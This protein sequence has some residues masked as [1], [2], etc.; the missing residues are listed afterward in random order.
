MVLLKPLKSAWWKTAKRSCPKF[1][2]NDPEEHQQ[3]LWTP[4]TP[5]TLVSNGNNNMNLQSVSFIRTS[6]FIYFFFNSHAPTCNSALWLASYPTIPTPWWK[7]N[8]VK[9]LLFSEARCPDV[10][11]KMQSWVLCNFFVLSWGI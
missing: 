7:W 9:G 10:T 11:N 5:N 4:L 6:S 3:N 1:L 8:A 2:Y